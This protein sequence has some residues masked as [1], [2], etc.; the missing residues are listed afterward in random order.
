MTAPEPTSERSGIQS[1]ERVLRVLDVIGDSPVGATA[2]EISDEL[3]LT[4]STTYRLLKTLRGRDY[5]TRDASGRRYLL[6]RTVDNLGRALRY[7]L[8]VGPAMRSILRS[9]H[10]S[11]HAAVYLTMHRGADIAIAHIEDSQQHRRIGQLHVGFAEATHAT[12]FGKVMLA[13][14]GDA[15]L[16]QFLERNSPTALTRNTLTSAA[17]LGDQLQ[18]VRAQ[19]LA[20]EVEEYMPR[21]ACVA[22][23][24]KTAT[25]R[26]IG[27]VAV[28]VGAEEVSRR[29][30]DLERAVRRGAWQVSSHVG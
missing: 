26:T 18:E 6:G 17:K 27:S 12:A 22:A 8:V 1:A 21:L 9:V 5:I 28:S 25:G 30:L 3:G 20:V 11:A 15:E 14:M 7:Q 16:S 29:A 10:E 4:L 23:P 2:L 24:V 13:S 19:Q